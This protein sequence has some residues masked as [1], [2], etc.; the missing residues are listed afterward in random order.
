MNRHDEDAFEAAYCLD[1]EERAR[2]DAE[3]A[4]D[5][6][7]WASLCEQADEVLECPFCGHLVDVLSAAIVCPNCEV[8]WKTADEMQADT[9]VLAAEGWPQ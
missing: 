8:A 5:A 3:D 2:R 9:A 4:E 6:A 7:A 1:E